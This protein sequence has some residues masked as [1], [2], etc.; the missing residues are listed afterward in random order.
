MICEL[1]CLLDRFAPIFFQ[2]LSRARQVRSYAFALR[3]VT[4]IVLYTT[5]IAFYC[6]ILR[7]LNRVCA[8][9]TAVQSYRYCLDCRYNCFLHRHL[10]VYRYYDAPTRRSDHLFKS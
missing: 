7:G 9:F 2:I 6:L 1:S 5:I 4:R 10:G 8:E 3:T